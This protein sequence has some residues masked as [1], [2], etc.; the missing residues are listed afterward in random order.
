MNEASN[1][2]NQSSLPSPDEEIE[3]LKRMFLFEPGWRLGI[4]RGSTREFCYM[5]APGQDYYHRLLDGEIYLTRDDE[6]ICFACASRRGLITYEPKQLRDSL[7]AVAADLE[8]VPL[9]LDW[10]DPKRTNA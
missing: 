6:R 5:I 8:A 4:K 2:S 7:V 9:E 3:P 10:R 1:T